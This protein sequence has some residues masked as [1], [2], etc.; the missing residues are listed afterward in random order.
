MLKKATH[1]TRDEAH[2]SELEYTEMMMEA[3]LRQ[4]S[5]S[6]CVFY[7]EQKNVRVVAHGDDFTVL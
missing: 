5:F 6:A 1:G 3:G 7:H 2:N 4:G